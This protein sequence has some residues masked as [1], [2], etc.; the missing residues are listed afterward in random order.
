M[1][2]MGGVESTEHERRKV[3]G[4]GGGAVVRVLNTASSLVCKVADIL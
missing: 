2:R 3:G 4:R 1:W